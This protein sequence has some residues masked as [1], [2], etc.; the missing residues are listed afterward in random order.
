MGVSLHVIDLFAGAGG[1]SC[2]FLQAGFSVPLAIERDLWASETYALNHPMTNLITQDI[3][4][5][6]D[7][8]FSEYRGADVVMGGPPCQG[9]SISA[10]NRR[11]KDDPRNYLYLEFI[12]VVSIILPKVVLIENVKEIK[13]FKLPDGRLLCDDIRERLAALGYESEILTLNASDFGVP[14]ARIRTFILAA[15]DAIRLRQAV[16]NLLSGQTI[17]KDPF[18]PKESFPLN[19]WDAIS[20]LPAVEPWKVSEDAVLSYAS[21][22]KNLYQKLLRGQS[23]SVYNHVP[24]RHTPRMIE[25]FRHFIGEANGQTLSLPAELSPRARGNPE[26]ISGKSYDQNHRRLDPNKLSPTITASFYSSFIHPSQPRNLTVREAARL[27]S[28]P[29]NYIFKGKRT[30]L[31]KKLLARKGEIGDLFL[32][33]FNQVGNSV[34]PLLAKKLAL[35]IEKIIQ[36]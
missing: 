17:P 29:D 2:G 8:D 23:P 13:R 22:P 25:R 3:R 14:Q 5:I 35:Q 11:N 28:F 30:T 10:S 34:P 32:D 1:L 18:A 6:A 20:D 31:S 12:R 7:M 33:Q 15:R 24:M 26:I 16:G 19:L 21:E 9:F 27:Q 36:K 4:E